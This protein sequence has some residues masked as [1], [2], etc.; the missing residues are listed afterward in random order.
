ML[1]DF[2]WP[3]DAAG[4]TVLA[5]AVAVGLSTVVVLA[6]V[7]VNFALAGRAPGRVARV[8]RSPVATA[9]MLAF[10]AAFYLLL[11]FRV[12]EVPV[13]DGVLRAG[14]ALCGAALVVAG[15]VVNVLGRLELGRNWADQVTVYER[16]TLVE[17]GVFGFVRHPLYASLIWMF[18]GAALV[19][20]NAAA[21]AANLLVFVPA[22][23]FRAR[24]EERLLGERFA[25][26]AGYRAR[27]GML[28]PR[29]RR[30]RAVVEVR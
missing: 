11:R 9:S 1:N 26:Y 15:A 8:Q 10:F 2:A 25:G 29:F 20:R 5:A 6:A 24:Q 4:W 21:F 27:V 17:R 3:T 30:A 18:A 12:G 16:Q 19:Y 13:G 22:M 28:F 23:V 14:L 7:A